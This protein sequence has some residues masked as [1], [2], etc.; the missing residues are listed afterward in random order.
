[1]VYAYRTTH[2]SMSCEH[3]NQVNCDF[4]FFVKKMK[5]EQLLSNPASPGIHISV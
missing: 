3:S 1:M 4:F 2:V 5:T